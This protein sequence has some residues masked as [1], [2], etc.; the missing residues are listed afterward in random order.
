MQLYME[1]FGDRMA[2][3]FGGKGRIFFELKEENVPSAMKIESLKMYEKK[4]QDA[5]DLGKI[6]YA[7]HT[8]Q[9]VEIQG[10]HVEDWAPKNQFPMRMLKFFV[11]RMRKRRMHGISGSIFSTDTKTGDKLDVFKS[12]GFNVREKGAMAG[13]REYTVEIEL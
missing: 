3:M 7:I 13:H 5:R 6:I 9:K 10:F 8:D 2:A 4:G 1:P 12:Q 11:S